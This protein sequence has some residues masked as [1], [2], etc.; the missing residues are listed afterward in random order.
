MK[1]FYFLLSMMMALCGNSALA[2]MLS[3]DTPLYEMG[4]ELAIQAELPDGYLHR[5][6]EAFISNL[7]KG[8]LEQANGWVD[9]GYVKPQEAASIAK[10]LGKPYT[11]PKRSEAGKTYERLNFSLRDLGLCGACASNVA[12]GAV[13]HPNSKLAQLANAAVDG[14]KAALAELESADTGILAD[15]SATPTTSPQAAVNGGMI[16]IYLSIIFIFI[17][18]VRKGGHR[19]IYAVVIA[20]TVIW[21]HLGVNED[22]K[23]TPQE[24]ACENNWQQCSDNA[25]LANNYRKWSTISGACKH[26]A[27]EL[28]KYGKPDFPWVAFGTFHTGRTYIDS[29]IAYAIETKAKFQNAFGTTVNNTRVVCEYDLKTDKVLRVFID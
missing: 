24:R 5:Y 21:A 15:L 6:H 27:S 11:V 10:A 3:C 7:C 26:A 9:N 28:A 17:W 8:D 4:D 20:I 2:K 18:G 19:W 12:A 14:D 16:I 23:K 1:R 22:S 13:E 25:Q 29:G